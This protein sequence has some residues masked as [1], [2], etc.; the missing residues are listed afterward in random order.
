M[1]H[2]DDIG[3][4]DGHLDKW[5]QKLQPMSDVKVSPPGWIIPGLLVP[6]LNLMAGPPKTFKSFLV[7][8][9]IASVLEKKPVGRPAD[10][11]VAV[12]RGPVAYFAAEQSAGS[13]RHIYETRV[14]KRRLKRNGTSWD[15]VVPKDTWLWQVD[16]ETMDPAYDFAE[17]IRDWRPMILVL[18]PFVYFHAM[19][20]NDPKVVRPLVPLATAMQRYGGA[21]VVVHHTKKEQSGGAVAGANPWDKVRGTS[22]LWAMAQA[23]IMLSR[24]KG[25]LIE[26][27]TEFKDHEGGKWVWN[28]K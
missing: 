1:S 26:V 27:T 19:D 16:P 2:D 12:K 13:L 6:G 21:L 28:P 14:L 20:E 18:D 10:G 7:L 17:F 5:R 8:N 15:F 23:G 25:G 9:M 3:E 11:R 24:L 22:A 4:D